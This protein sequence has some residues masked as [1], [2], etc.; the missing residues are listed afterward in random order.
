MLH[1]HGDKNVH[2]N[3]IFIQVY[4]CFLSKHMISLSLDDR[5]LSGRK[6]KNKTKTTANQ[7]KNSH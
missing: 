3:E 1:A 5:V 7:G 4:L 6:N 2:E